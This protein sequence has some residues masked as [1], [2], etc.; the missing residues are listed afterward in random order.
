MVIVRG[1]G[2]SSTSFSPH[3][4]GLQPAPFLGRPNRGVDQAPAC[5]PSLVLITIDTVGA[6]H[7]GCDGYRRIETPSTDQLASGGIR[8][9]HAHAQVPLTLP[10]HTVIMTGTYPMFNGVRDLT[11]PGLNTRVPTL[12]GMILRQNGYSAAAF[13]SSFVLNSMWG[14]N[15]GFE[16]YFEAMMM[17]QTA[18]KARARV[19]H[20]SRSLGYVAYL[21]P[22]AVS[23]SRLSRSDPK[24]KIR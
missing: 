4:W 2:L 7:L 22:A 6:D 8:F 10:S 11:S 24:A 20:C 21:A 16:G 17:R 19:R 12:A 9:E 15:R 14:L 1:I 13:V 23:D 5:T 3:S 18:G